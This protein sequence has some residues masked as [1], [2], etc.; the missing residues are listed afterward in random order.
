MGEI[1]LCLNNTPQRLYLVAD[2][3]HRADCAGLRWENKGFGPVQYTE[4]SWYFAA[5]TGT[6]GFKL[7]VPAS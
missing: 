5:P 2:D 3:G 6:K 7:F 4:H 1:A